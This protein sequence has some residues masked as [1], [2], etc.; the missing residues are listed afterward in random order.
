MSESQKPQST[1]KTLKRDYSTDI[2]ILRKQLWKTKTLLCAS[3]PSVPS[4]IQTNP[5]SLILLTLKSRGMPKGIHTRQ[6]PYAHLALIWGNANR[7]SYRWFLDLV[8]PGS[9][10]IH[11]YTTKRTFVYLSC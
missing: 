5:S 8:N 6:M 11:V 1:L 7:C 4:V 2:F 9:D 3:V 10:N